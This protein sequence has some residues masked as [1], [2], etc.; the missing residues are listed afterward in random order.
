MKNPNRAEQ[1]FPVQTE[2][3]P[4]VLDTEDEVISLDRGMRDLR[5]A[6]LVDKLRE[7]P[8]SLSDTEK[9]QINHSLERRRW[10]GVLRNLNEGDT[11]ISTL[12]ATSDLLSI[13][14]LNDNIFGPQTTDS[15]ILKRRKLTESFLNLELNFAGVDSRELEHVNLEQNYKFGVFKIPAKY[16][17]DT[18][19]IFNKVCA[20][21][22]EEMKQYI[23]RLADEEQSKSPE[24]TALLQKF[25]VAVN[26]EGYRM[27]FGITKVQS[28]NLED[29]ILATNG[30]LQMARA[31]SLD[32][33]SYGGEFS[34]EKIKESIDGISELRNKIFQNGNK[35]V[36]KNGTVHEIFSQK[37]GLMELNRDL[38]REVRK[39]K[40]E[41]QTDQA[42]I[43]DDLKKYVKSLNI[44]DVV[45]PFT[46]EEIDII[47]IENKTIDSITSGITDNKKEKGKQA[48]DILD[49][50]EKD[51]HFTSESRFHAEAVKH[52][53]CAY[54]SLDVLDV[55]VD[56]LL[57]FENRTQMVANKVLT[58]NEA[59]MEA[60]D[61][62]TEKLRLMRETVYKI[63]DEFGLVKNERMD[64]LVGGDEL[65]LAIN[66][67]ATSQKGEKIFD[68]NDKVLN[69]LIHRLKKETNSRVVKTVIAQSKRHSSSD[70][71]V[72]KMKEHLVALKKAEDGTSQAKQ[73]EAEL[74]KLNKFSKENPDNQPAKELLGNLKN[75]VMAESDGHF[76]V[77]TEHGP[78]LTLKQILEQ[79][80]LLYS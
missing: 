60:G 5:Y 33:N 11:V 44:F 70:N 50:N 77:R 66:L 69:K 13:K 76:V 46:A 4:P 41:T 8:A 38:L 31:S 24:K 67:D 79:F 58:F 47:K 52:L 51:Q 72:N 64:G 9:D 54:L 12:S 56:Q 7:N 22:D 27:S 39:D 49:R 65:T 62:M 43:L 37:D 3:K 28:E 45:K 36:S 68:D 15:I 48:A 26:S 21:V 63:C 80:N 2:T 57:D 23:I 75:F 17:L 6:E 1:M 25:R 16:D 74:R 42:N 20:Q 29:A 59:S 71:T 61:M 55:G 73:V 19:K 10:G 78:D 34:N 14:N 18:V 53:N 32:V 35:I 30:S 40:F